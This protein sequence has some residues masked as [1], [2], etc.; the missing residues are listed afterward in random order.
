MSIFKVNQ[1]P[2]VYYFKKAGIL[3]GLLNCVVGQ[4][5]HILTKE[6]LEKDPVKKA[7][8]EDTLLFVG[9]SPLMA[10]YPIEDPD[11]PGYVRLANRYELVNMGK[12]KLNDGEKI[13][14]V[15]KVILTVPKPNEFAKWDSSLTVWT[16]DFDKLPDG[17]KIVDRDAQKIRYVESPNYAAKWDKVAEEWKTDV[18]DL[19]DGEKLLVSG[20]IE[21]VEQPVDDIQHIW[22]WNKKTFLWENII[23]K[24]QLRKNYFKIIEQHKKDCIDSGFMFRGYQQKCRVLDMNWITQRM[25]Q[26]RDDALAKDQINFKYELINGTNKDKLMKVGWVF[27]YNEVLLLDIIDFK[28]M[29]DLGAK[30][31]EGAYLVEEVL[32]DGQLNFELTLNDFRLKVKEYSKVDVYMGPPL[33]EEDRL[34]TDNDPMKPMPVTMFFRMMEEPDYEAEGRRN[35]PAH[36]LGLRGSE[37]MLAAHYGLTLEEAAERKFNKVNTLEEKPVE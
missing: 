21:I 32:K 15:D 14:H 25:N 31:T 5:D 6:E 7:L 28:E 12:D 30:F 22:G 20:K 37:V 3:L 2:T 24:E 10:G 11:R 27:N 23:T 16:T 33:S 8:Y 19:R 29:F 9:N 18:N 34:E 17:W 1:D 26:T 36:K 4:E 13:N 35:N